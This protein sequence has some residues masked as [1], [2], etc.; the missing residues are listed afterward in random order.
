MQH[1]KIT[2]YSTPSC[3]WCSRAKNY[4]KSL[5]LNFKNID[6]SKDQKAAEKMVK[7]SGQMGVPVIEIG[8]KVIVGFDKNKIDKLLGV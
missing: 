2:V 5:G 1:V 6:V 4:F 8:N 7:K 3:P